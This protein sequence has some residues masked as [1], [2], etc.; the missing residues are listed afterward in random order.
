VAGVWVG[1]DEKKDSLGRGSDG[2]RTALP[3][4]M[5]FWAAAMKDKPIED[6]AVPGNIVFVPVD[7]TGHPASAGRDRS[8]R[9]PITFRTGPPGAH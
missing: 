2:A 6:F 9:Q 7:S 8:P 4:W 3:I 1:F 5:E